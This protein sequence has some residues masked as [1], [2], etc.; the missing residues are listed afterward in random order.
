M[1]RKTHIHER[2]DW[3]AFRWDGAAPANQ[4][5]AVRHRQGRLLGRMATLGFPLRAEATLTALTQDA[6]KTSEIE[7]ELLDYQQVR[8]SPARRLGLEKAGIPN[9]DRRAEAIAAVVLDAIRAFDRPLTAER[10]F[11]W[12]HFLFPS[13]GTGRYPITVGAWRT[14]EHGAKL[15][16][17]AG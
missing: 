6:P 1:R 16:R 13:P 8:S 2:P 5:A 15:D 7:G 17:T 14:D 3:P 4:L 12:H 11:A 10:L 9:S